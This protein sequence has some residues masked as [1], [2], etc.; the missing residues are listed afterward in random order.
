[1]TIGMKVDYGDGESLRLVDVEPGLFSA[2]A[3][4]EMSYRDH[5]TTLMRQIPLQV[6]WMH[7]KYFLQHVAFIQS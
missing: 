6:R 5:S 7:P 2:S 4:V 3:F 1:M